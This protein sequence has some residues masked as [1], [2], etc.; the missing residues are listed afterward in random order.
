MTRPTGY[1]PRAFPSFAVTA[2]L[3]VLTIKADDLCVLL[4]ERGQ[5]PFAGRWALPGGFVKPDESLEEAA[6]RELLEET[7]VSGHLEQL[8]SFGEPDRDPR[9]RVVTVAFL[10]LLPDA[11]EPVAS[12]DAAQAR[13]WAVKDLPD[14]AF[15]HAEILDAGVERARAKLEYTSLATEFCGRTFTLGE[16]R[17]V[18]EIIW[19]LD[20]DPANFRRKVLNAKRFVRPTG[21]QQSPGEAGGRPAELYRAGGATTLHPPMTR[22]A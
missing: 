12:T 6:K 15:D 13:F 16:L 8:R 3:V 18:Y 21:K 22:H 11:A 2:D 10:A 19:D 17:R 5:D 1:D 20:L 14:L 7:G 9:M 4:I